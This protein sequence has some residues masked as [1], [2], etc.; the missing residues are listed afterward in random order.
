MSKITLISAT[1][2][3]GEI[4]RLL[5]MIHVMAGGLANA[6]KDGWQLA[7]TATYPDCYVLT[8]W[9]N[10]IVEVGAETTTN[11]DGEKDHYYWMA[12]VPP[13]EQD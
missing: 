11:D 1:E 5:N 13:G 4:Y 12:R 10:G 8:V 2:Q 6:D 7:R 9:T 3:D